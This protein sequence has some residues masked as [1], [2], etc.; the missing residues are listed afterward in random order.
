MEASIKKKKRHK[1]N[2]KL[3]KAQ[4]VSEDVPGKEGNEAYKNNGQSGSEDHFSD[5]NKKLTIRFG[6]KEREVERALAVRVNQVIFDTV[7]KPFLCEK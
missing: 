1:R 2:E 6:K 5:D 7:P 4:G 3:E